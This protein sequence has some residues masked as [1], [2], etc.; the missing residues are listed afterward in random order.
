LINQL[1]IYIR[2]DIVLVVITSTLQQS[3][4]HSN[5]FTVL[6]KLIVLKVMNKKEHKDL[7]VLKVLAN[8][9]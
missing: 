9:P 6:K 8:N 4:N 5:T 3:N 7:V 2:T 1:N